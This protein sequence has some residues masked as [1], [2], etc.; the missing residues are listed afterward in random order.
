MHAFVAD[1]GVMR[2][3]TEPYERASPK[4]FKNVFMHLTNFNI[5]KHSKN[6]VDDSTVDDVLKP[7][8]ATKRT[9]TA[10]LA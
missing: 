9:L 1:E 3:C 2:F 8:N 7:N 4:N 10:L 6:C 5:N